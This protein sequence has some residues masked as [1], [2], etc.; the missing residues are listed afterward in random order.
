MLLEITLISTWPKNNWVRWGEERKD[1][2]I[3]CWVAI[4]VILKKFRWVIYY[5]FFSSSWELSVVYYF[6]VNGITLVKNLTESLKKTLFFLFVYSTLIIIFSLKIFLVPIREL[7]LN[8]SIKYNFQHIFIKRTKITVK[9]IPINKGT[10][11]T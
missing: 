10:R 1:L 8:F 9:L 4:Y 5:Y 6:E 7:F 2:K 11:N 3:T